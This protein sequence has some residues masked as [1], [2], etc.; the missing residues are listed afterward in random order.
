[1]EHESKVYNFEKSILGVVNSNVAYRQRGSMPQFWDFD[2]KHIL[3]L[4]VFFY[5]LNKINSKSE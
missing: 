5:N 1:M 3:F 4:K 2:Y